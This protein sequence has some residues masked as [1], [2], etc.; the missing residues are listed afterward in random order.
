M[1]FFKKH[2]FW[3]R[4]DRAVSQK[5]RENLEEGDTNTGQMLRGQVAQVLEILGQRD[6]EEANLR[7]CMTDY[8]KALDKK[9][10]LKNEAENKI[11]GLEERLKEKTEKCVKWKQLIA[12]K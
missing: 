7:R 12:R 6:R 1:S 11:C 2:E 5:H 3:R 9:E 4:R 8:E 10:C